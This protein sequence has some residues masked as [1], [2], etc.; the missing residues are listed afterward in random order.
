MEYT[1]NEHLKKLSKKLYV[2]L[3]FPQEMKLTLKYS[4]EYGERVMLSP[5]SPSP[6]AHIMKVHGTTPSPATPGASADSSQNIIMAL[7][8]EGIKY[9]FC[10]VPFRW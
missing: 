4:P 8:R 5:D 10:L 1:D 2:P 3:E 9:G 6:S 7:L